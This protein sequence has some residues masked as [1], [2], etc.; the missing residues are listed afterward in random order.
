VN[1][2]TLA[3]ARSLE[4]IIYFRFR[5][6]RAESQR[7]NAVVTL[8]AA[9]EEGDRGFAGTYRKRK[10][11]ETRFTLYHETRWPVSPQSITINRI[12]HMP[13]KN[14]LRA[15]ETDIL[16]VSSHAR[17]ERAIDHEDLGLRLW[18]ARSFCIHATPTCRYFG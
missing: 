6:P 18:Q 1:Q 4:E 11:L 5:S 9:V 15:R 14:H 12:L 7:P 16:L 17:S 10:R 2:S 8:S 13:T 3:S